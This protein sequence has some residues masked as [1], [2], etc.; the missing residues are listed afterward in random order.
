MTPFTSVAGP[1]TPII[2]S[3]TPTHTCQKNWFSA[4]CEK[5]TFSQ[6]LYRSLTPTNNGEIIRPLNSEKTGTPS[7]AVAVHICHSAS[8]SPGDD[9]QASP[10]TTRLE[11]EHGRKQQEPG[12]DI[13][14]SQMQSASV[15][16]RDMHARGQDFRAGEFASSAE[17]EGQMP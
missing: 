17:E 12:Q 15:S 9:R 11:P 13:A 8:C 1:T 2:L 5:T 10:H 7:G 4:T 14:R 3:L 6:V 16:Q